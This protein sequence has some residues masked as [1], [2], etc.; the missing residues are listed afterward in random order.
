MRRFLQGLGHVIAPRVCRVCGQSL[1]GAEDVMCLKCL[2][3]LPRTGEHRKPFNIIHQRLGH[4]AVVDRAAGWFFYTKQSAYARMLVDAKYAS[5]PGIAEGLGRVCAAELMADGFFDDIDALVPMPLHWTKQLRR[6]YNQAY[7]ICLGISR[8]TGLP[9]AKALRAAKPHGVQSR[10]SRQQR[11]AS[12]AG[13]LA[14]ADA[15][16][17]AGR[18][19]LFVDDIVTT[20]ATA[21]EAVRVLSRAL[22]ASVS[23]LC[24]GLTRQQGS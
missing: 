5:Q 23:V 16:L 14:V 18:R 4:N 22:P 24:L 12:I 3:E 15:R 6:G 13:T 11:H 21:S 19:L 8:V 7:E 10:L 17:V 9:I 2:L 20:G 1:N